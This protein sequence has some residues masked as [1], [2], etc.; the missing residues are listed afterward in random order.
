M[1]MARATGR[2]KMAVNSLVRK[3]RLDPAYIDLLPNEPDPIIAERSSPQTE[4]RSIEAPDSSTKE[5][6]ERYAAVKAILGTNLGA[7]AKVRAITA[8]TE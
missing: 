7:E 3:I 4:F 2:T 8:I 5:T 1:Q 6:L